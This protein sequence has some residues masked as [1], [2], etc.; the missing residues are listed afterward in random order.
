M[1]LDPSLLSLL[2]E[3]E[4]SIERDAISDQRDIL[5][6]DSTSSTESIGSSSKVLVGAKDDRVDM[7]GDVGIG[8]F[9]QGGSD[10][11]IGLFSLGLRRGRR[12]V[13]RQRRVD[14]ERLD[15]ESFFSGTVDSI[16]SYEACFC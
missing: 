15:S 5:R 1:V 9:S 3:L 10:Q 6:V 16:V 4:L 11:T 14:N 7:M 2:V 13:V 12:M 8:I